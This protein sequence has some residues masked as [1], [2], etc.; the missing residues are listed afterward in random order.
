MKLFYKIL[1]L[2]FVANLLDSGPVVAGKRLDSLKKDA[3]H[4]QLNI[5][6]WMG[7]VRDLLM[8]GHKDLA[9]EAV[10]KGTEIFPDASTM[11][12]AYGDVLSMTGKKQQAMLYYQKAITQDHKNNPA[13]EKLARIGAGK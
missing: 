12:E 10:K 8:A 1:L 2:G 4:Y 3:I 7:K 13:K 11:S 6:D 5:D 9:M